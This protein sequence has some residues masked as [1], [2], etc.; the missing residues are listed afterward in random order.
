MVVTIERF[1]DQVSQFME[2]HQL[3]APQIRKKSSQNYTDKLATLTSVEQHLT[4]GSTS[5][6]LV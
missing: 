1:Y 3:S 2:L 4:K 6:I 5:P